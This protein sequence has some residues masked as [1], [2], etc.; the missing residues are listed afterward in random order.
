MGHVPAGMFWSAAQHF[1]IGDT[2]GTVIVVPVIM[3]GF[4]AA[5]RRPVIRLDAAMVLD[6]AVFGL[7][8]AGAF[9]LIFSPRKANELQF[10]YLLFLPVIWIAI[11]AGFVGAAAGIFLLHVVFFVITTLEGYQATDFMAFQMLMLA[12]SAAGLLLGAMVSERRET[13]ARIREQ[14]AELSRMSRYMTAGVTGFSLAHQISQP[15]SSV[16]NYLHAARRLL[17]TGRYDPDAVA[18]AL[19]KAEAE[20]RRAREVLERVRDFLSRGRVE[21]APVDLIAMAAKI[22]ALAR[23]DAA[24]RG[25]QIRVDD[26]G[27]PTVMADPVQIEQVLL[28]LVANGVDAAAE[29]GDAKGV[30]TIRIDRRERAAGIGVEDNGP[31]VAP[32][33]AGR[34]LEPFETT[35]PRG[36]GLGLALSQQIVEAHLGRLVW[37]GLEPQGTKFMFELRVDGPERHAA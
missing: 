18:S 1:W 22:A 19:D 16:G 3:A 15:L 6:V 17:G 23:A 35:K 33:I 32:E 21:P 24:A 4:A 31:G 11:R 36:M 9:W 2:V 34:L 14:Q 7:G 37:V 13:E 25:V 28:N 27:P 30:V 12:L 29:R 8:L 26:L 5:A 20:T 10:F